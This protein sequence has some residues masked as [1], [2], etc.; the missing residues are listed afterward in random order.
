[1]VR[2][3]Y[4]PQN[5]STVEIDRDKLTSL[6]QVKAV[7]GKKWPGFFNNFSTRFPALY[8]GS[9]TDVRGQ[10]EKDG[11]MDLS[12]MLYYKRSNLELFSRKYLEQTP[13]DFFATIDRV[14]EELRILP[15]KIVSLKGLI[16]KASSDDEGIACEKQ[17]LELLAPVYFRLREM[18]YGHW[19]LTM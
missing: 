15:E 8:K 18:G 17:L 10:L 1:M 14:T 13:R 19:E 5:M 16:V 2:L 6:E 12:F 3:H 7:L 9:L 4:R 11:A